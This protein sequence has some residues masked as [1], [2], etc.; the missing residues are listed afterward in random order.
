MK[1]RQSVRMEQPKDR[2]RQA[3]E[4][5]G[6]KRPADVARA[7]KK[8]INQNTLTSHLNGNRAISRKAAEKYATIFDSKAGWILFDDEE[9]GLEDVNVPVLSMVSAGNLR[10]QPTV[11]EEDILR[12]IKVSDL[13]RGEWV[14]LVVEG[15]SMDRVAPPGSTIL[16]NRSDD[17]LIDGRFYVFSLDN[18]AATFKQYRTSPF[19]HLRPYSTNL[20]HMTTPVDGHELYVFG[21]ARRVINDI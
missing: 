2:L 13:P 3:M 4:E 15:D 16:V 8:E 9:D 19:E 11:T 12:W 1:F 18:G 20:D 17:R 14:A 5:A 7:F 10:D 21:R 6:F